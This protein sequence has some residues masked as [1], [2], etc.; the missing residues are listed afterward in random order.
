MAKKKV[1]NGV[2]AAIAASM[3]IKAGVK[4]AS[5][6]KKTIKS[7]KAEESSEGEKYKFGKPGMYNK[8]TVQRS[9]VS[10]GV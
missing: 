5:A 6:A 7:E 1:K 4:A 3:S 8:S 2:K 9:V 10:K